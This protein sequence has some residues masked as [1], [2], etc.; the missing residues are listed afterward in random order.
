VAVVAT[1]TASGSVYVGRGLTNMRLAMTL[2]LATTLGAIAGGI[3]AALLP[4][5]ALLAAFA[6]FTLLTAGL[7]FTRRGVGEA[8]AARPAGASPQRSEA[9][10]HL[11]GTYYDEQH[12]RL[13][14]YRVR[15][16]PVG[17]AVSAVAG[18]VTGSSAWGAGSS[19]SRP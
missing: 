11:A 19:R 13:L 18:G 6:A 1:S 15:G 7:L 10:G 17:M 3:S 2:E 14:D 4:E 9:R 8:V 12:G 5:R 16:L